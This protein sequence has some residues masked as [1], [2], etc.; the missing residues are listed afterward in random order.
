MDS[1]AQYYSEQRRV[2][3]DSGSSSMELLV[4][5]DDEFEGWYRGLRA[6]AP[7][8][9]GTETYSRTR[10]RCWSGLQ[11]SWIFKARCSKQ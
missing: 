9:G 10:P 3:L 5:R 8:R 7:A 1:P 4:A 6:E 11:A 2:Q